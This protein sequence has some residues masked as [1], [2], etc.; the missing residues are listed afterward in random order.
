MSKGVI[1]PLIIILITGV[2][3]LV[4]GIIICKKPIIYYK[5][6]EGHFNGSHFK[7]I[8]ICFCN[9]GL[10]P[11]KNLEAYI[12]LTDLKELVDLDPNIENLEYIWY[13]TS[14]KVFFESNVR[15]YYLIKIDNLHKFKKYDFSFV[16]NRNTELDD[17]V[18]TYDEGGNYEKVPWDNNFNMIFEMHK[19]RV[20]AVSFFILILLIVPIIFLLVRLKHCHNKLNICKSDPQVAGGIEIRDNIK[21]M[22]VKDLISYLERPLDYFKKN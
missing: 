17:V 9:A 8:N 4:F 21:E 13:K 11:A 5:Y 22:K 20:A 12:Y 10:E 19:K 2:S 3:G 1:I 18:I 16:I 14:E 15:P 6:S 7:L